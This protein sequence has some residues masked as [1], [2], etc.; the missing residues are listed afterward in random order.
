M[1]AIKTEATGEIEA[2][3]AASRAELTTE[4]RKQ[5][6]P[7]IDRS[8]V[9]FAEDSGGS[10]SISERYAAQLQNWDK[11]TTGFSFIL[12]F[13]SDALQSAEIPYKQIRLDAS[14]VKNILEKHNGMTI[15]TFL[16]IPELL[17][18]PI[19]VIDSKQNANS[20][21]IMGDL[22]DS[23][24]KLVTVVLLLTPT[25]R[26]GNQLDI[27]KVS[28]A[29]G[30]GHIESLFKYDDGTSVKIRFADKKRIQDWLN[31]NRL[32]LPLHSF[33]LDSKARQESHR[34][35]TENSSLADTTSLAS[36]NSIPQNSSNVN[37]FSENSFDDVE[38][39]KASQF[40]II[41]KNNR[42]HGKYSRETAETDISKITLDEV[43]TLRS[44][45]RK[46]IN[47]FTSEDIK[48]AEP[49]A[50][51]FYAELGTKSPFFRAWFGDWRAYDRS[52]IKTVT[53]ENIDLADVVMQNGDYGNSDT[54]WTIHAGALLQGDTVSHARGERI[55]VKALKDVENILENAVLLD[56]EISK[57]NNKN[58]SAGTAFMH[59]LYAPITYNEDIYI[60][61]ISVE[62][63][64]NV[65]DGKIKRRGYNLRA[66]KIEA[67]NRSLTDKQSATAPVV[68][69]ASINSI[70]DLHRFV[71]RFDENFSP[72]SVN[73]VL[74]NE[75]GTPK[76]FYH[77]TSRQFSI[78]DPAEMSHKEG[79]YF[80]AENKE[81]ASE[82][83]AFSA[84]FRS[85]CIR[86]CTACFHCEERA[87]AV[88]N[89]DRQNTFN[90]HSVSQK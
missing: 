48:K 59:K 3:D 43:K 9:V 84:R 33:N 5:K 27:L 23:N 62:E 64:L 66:I 68:D 13:T 14:K 49:W 25:S 4:G 34:R 17:E 56:T 19:V 89:G 7:D 6:R 69:S 32:Q 29:Q 83:K 86:Y 2:R 63:F 60:A 20:R 71:K 73:P 35:V 31:A 80:F 30:R 74:L 46:S 47:N 36:D 51:K 70:A 88:P 55:S 1:V 44:I 50:R 54:G 41:E 39:F 45:G 61:K 16:E 77:G 82:G 15:D 24:G 85:R 26:K 42:T 87:Y 22:H 79:S 76:V 78:F 21:I 67:V 40:E 8:D 81:D 12:G 52:K 37:S 90:I 57:R 18:H 10:Y 72:K 11:T 38:K 28:S 58:K 53:V 75:D 65:S